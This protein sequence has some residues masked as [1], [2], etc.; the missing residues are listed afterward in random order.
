MGAAESLPQ[1]RMVCITSKFNKE[2]DKGPYYTENIANDTN[3][4]MAYRR[5]VW[6]SPNL[7]QMVFMSIAPLG[8]IP[9]ELHP[10][11][12]QFIRIETGKG[13]AIIDGKRYLLKDDSAVIVPAGAEHRIVNTSDSEALKLYT[14]YSPQKHKPS[15]LEWTPEEE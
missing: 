12:D 9:K 2:S 10:R 11:T 3:N 14:I 15:T 4:N 1:H 7:M 5:V 6:T 13:E 8:E